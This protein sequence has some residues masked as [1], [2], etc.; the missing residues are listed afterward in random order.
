MTPIDPAFLLIPI[1]QAVK[2]VRKAFDSLSFRFTLTVLPQSDGSAGIF[3]P[4]DDIF[5]EAAPKIVQA[6][7][8]AASD[9]TSPIS[10]EDIL[11]LT[12]CD[13]IV[14]ALKMICDFQS[15]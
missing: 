6:V 3:Q 1:L 9:N 12:R 5:D 11:F 14:G 10:Q 13:C 4:L 7:N 2:P 15:A 8:G